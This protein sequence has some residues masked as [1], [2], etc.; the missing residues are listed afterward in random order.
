MP[1]LYPEDRLYHRDALWLQLLEGDEALLGINHYAQDS[2]G[3]VVFLDL[4]RVGA[5]IR[6]DTPLGT[7][8]SRKAVSDMIA[9]ADGTVLEVNGRLRNEPTLIN[10]DPYG[11]GWT[12]RIRLISPGDIGHLHAAAAYLSL[13][14]LSD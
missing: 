5:T 4:P 1:T 6:C 11:E 2:L 12:L 8:E 7:V 9:P 14:G 13:M 10:S 3:E